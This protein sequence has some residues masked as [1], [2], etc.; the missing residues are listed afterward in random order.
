MN[1]FAPFLTGRTLIALPGMGDSRFD[2]AVIAICL[3][4]KGGAMGVDVGRAHDAI[5]FDDVLEQII[6]DEKGEL[7]AGSAPAPGE[8][9][10][11]GPIEPQR[12]F[13]IHSLD[14]E[15]ADT[16]QVGTRFGLSTTPSIVLDM[17][18]GKGP[19]RAALALGYAGWGPGQLDDEMT[20]NG[21]IAL[22]ID[23]LGLLD[24]PADER[25]QAALRL[26]GIDPALLSGQF[27][28]A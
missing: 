9:L 8:L 16:V 15:A 24:L 19:R 22:D 11:G 25:W 4:D 5:G 3:H 1:D 13:V 20:R 2:K 28:S 27:G 12:G 17:G 10:I 23:L 6:A 26:G 7:D 21:W 14:Y 18:L